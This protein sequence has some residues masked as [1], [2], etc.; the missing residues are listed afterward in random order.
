[1]RKALRRT[2]EAH[3]LAQIVAVF[4]AA[5]AVLARQADFEGHM[6]ADGEVRDGGPERGH[7]AGGFVA[8]CEW[9]AEDEIAIAA[10]REVVQVAAAEPGGADGDLDFVGGRG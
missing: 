9:G 5:C 1:M 4:V 3:F 6:V 10:V 8:E 7:H 2:A